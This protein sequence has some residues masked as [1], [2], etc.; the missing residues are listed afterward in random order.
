MEYVGCKYGV[1]ENVCFGEVVMFCVYGDD[2]KWYVEISKGDV[3][4]VDFVI[5][6]MGILYYLKW[7]EIVGKD[8]FVGEYWYIV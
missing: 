7:F 5:L 2:G 3:F 6:V 8:D 4:V 1:M